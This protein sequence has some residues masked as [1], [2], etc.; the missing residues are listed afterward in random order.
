MS[1]P[2]S[3]M[4]TPARRGTATLC[5]TGHPL[6]LSTIYFRIEKSVK[7][8][9]MPTKLALATEED[10]VKGQADTDVGLLRQQ[11]RAEV[12]VGGVSVRVAL[13]WRLQNRRERGGWS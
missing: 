6:V 2:P 9:S 1:W 7:S 8:I 3:L 12:S 5:P 13:C 10:V 11:G 4:W